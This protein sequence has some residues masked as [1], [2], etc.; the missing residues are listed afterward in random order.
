LD[1]KSQARQSDAAP[2]AGVAVGDII[3]GKYRV[4]RVLGQGGMGMVVAATH[5]ELDQLVAIKFLLPAAAANKSA[6][7]RF[8][9]EARASAKLRSDNVVHVTDVGT[10]DSGEPFIVMEYLEGQ[11]LGDV[12]RE[13]GPL[14]IDD[15]VDYVLQAC[16]ALAE[17]HAAGII[18]RDLKPANLFLAERQDT[19]RVVKVVDFGIS[20]VTAAIPT[21]KLTNTQDLMGSPL[22][23]SPEQLSLS[24]AIDGRSDIW[25]LGIILYELIGGEPPFQ[26]EGLPQLCTAVL[27]RPA[28]PIERDGLSPGLAAV[29]ARCLEKDADAR[30][31][32]VGELA[33][34]LA[35][36][37]PERS[38]PTLARIAR[39]G[40]VPPDGGSAPGARTST[41]REHRA[42][43]TGRHGDTASPWAATDLKT[44]PGSGKRAWIVGAAVIVAVAGLVVV[45]A[46]PNTLASWMSRDDDAGAPALAIPTDANVLAPSAGASAASSPRVVARPATHAPALG[47][48]H[49][50]AATGSS[51]LL[52][53][54][55]AGVRRIRIGLPIR[56]GVRAGIVIA[57]RARTAACVGV[58]VG[59]CTCVGIGACT[60]VGV[61][62][63]IDAC[64]RVAAE[65]SV[66][67][68]ASRAASV[69]SGNDILRAVSAH[70]SSAHTSDA[71]HAQPLPL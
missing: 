58:G 11:D 41:P 53:S 30:Y 68:R 49:A 12:L 44:K 64:I 38:R 25:S 20:K 24:H 66:A 34:A 37:A 69:G 8:A 1:V 45:V 67:A 33:T 55:S 29:I 47:S 35:E 65:L 4:E 16:A 48:H 40:A 71:L 70:G 39:L 9:R 46:R 2:P 15:A 31:A 42:I 51:S 28:P 5:I 18:H 6:V 56:V 54:R 61:G 22:Y 52:S 3:A 62:I 63:G 7:E 19:V 26:D 60:G 17:A 27:V 10:F 23:M 43:V 13:G 57:V 50:P 14:A 36:F 59:A 32:D 21:G